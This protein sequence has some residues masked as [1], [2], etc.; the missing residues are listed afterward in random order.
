MPIVVRLF[1]SEPSSGAKIIGGR[2]IFRAKFELH[3]HP[4]RTE[5][6]RINCVWNLLKG[7][8]G[9]QKD[10]VMLGLTRRES[11]CDVNSVK[12]LKVGFLACSNLCS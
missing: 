6:S 11:D 3:Y 1:L 10:E 8:D 5:R 9:A 4:I 2:Q 12:R 7:K